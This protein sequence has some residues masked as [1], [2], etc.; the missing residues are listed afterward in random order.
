MGHDLAL[1]AHLESSEVAVGEAVYATASG[2][3]A[4]VVVQ[5]KNVSQPWARFSS[6]SSHGE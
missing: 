3:K 5:E 4:S 1:E 2:R 6:K